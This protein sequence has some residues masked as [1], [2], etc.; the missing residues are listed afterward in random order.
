MAT[1]E[2]TVEG[3][4]WV[5]GRDGRRCT[6]MNCIGYDKA[7][8][9]VRVDAKGTIFIECRECG[10]TG[11]RETRTYKEVRACKG[12]GWKWAV[13]VHKFRSAPSGSAVFRDSELA[14]DNCDACEKEASARRHLATAAH[15]TAL[16]RKIREG[17]R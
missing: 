2:E 1:T 16:A 8:A 7:N 13:T 6:D 14:R 9:R 4:R 3:R 5:I 10:K 17:R 15:L 12:C 11:T